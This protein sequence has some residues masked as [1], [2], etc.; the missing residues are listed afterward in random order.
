[1][2]DQEKVNVRIVAEEVVQKQKRKEGAETQ[3]R[4]SDKLE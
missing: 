3:K 1:M 2:T 4:E